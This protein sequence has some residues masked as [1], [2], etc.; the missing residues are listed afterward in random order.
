MV[1]ERVLGRARGFTLLELLMAVVIVATALVSLG[2][3]VSQ[4]IGSAADSVNQR[5]AREACRARIEAIAAGDNVPDGGPIEGHE[6]FT[7]QVTR[8]ERS[9]GA[10]D[11]PDEKYIVVTVQVN[12]PSEREQTT[13]TGMPGATS[14]PKGTASIQLS[15]ILLPQEIRDRQRQALAGQKTQ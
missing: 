7:C 3:V 13:Q 4:G 15:T 10:A 11:T 6:T 12:Y 8:E 9:T 2:A 1:R 14:L 5:A